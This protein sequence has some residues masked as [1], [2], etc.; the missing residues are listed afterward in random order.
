VSRIEQPGLKFSLEALQIDQAWLDANTAM[1]IKDLSRLHEWPSNQQID[2]FQRSFRDRAVILRVLKSDLDSIDLDDDPFVRLTVAKGGGD[3]ISVHSGNPRALMVPW[4]ID[5][6]G[7]TYE[8]FDA[9]I[10]QA[11]LELLPQ[12]F[13]NRARLTRADLRQF[14][15][16]KV[17]QDIGPAWRDIKADH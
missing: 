10:S 16:D 6:H 8:S 4:S 1:A 11:V 9:R 15:T 13:P 17:V 7:K 12:G 3:A 5:D 2:L 14:L